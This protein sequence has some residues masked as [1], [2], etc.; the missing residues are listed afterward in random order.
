MMLSMQRISLKVRCSKQDDAKSFNATAKRVSVQA[1]T[2]RRKLEDTRAPV[3]RDNWNK[4]SAIAANDVKF[5]ND[6]LKELDVFHK[7]ILEQWKSTLTAST[8]SGSTD[9]VVA[10]DPSSDN[11]FKQ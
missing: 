7:D 8:N 6:V 4:V 11:I 1:Q 10:S 5:A 9:V 3:V 2:L